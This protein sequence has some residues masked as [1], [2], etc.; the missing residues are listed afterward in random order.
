MTSIRRF[1]VI[2]LLATI[3]LFN[4]IAAIQ[5]YRT[6]MR[7]TGQMLDAQLANVARVISQT[8]H[9]HID[10]MT[11]PAIGDLAVQI[12]SEKQRLLYHTSNTPPEPVSDLTEGFAYSNFAGYHWRIHRFF[13]HDTRQWI[14][15]AERMD[16]RYQVAESIVLKTLFPII[17][18]LPIIGL[19][20]WLIVGSGLRPLRELAHQLGVKKSSDLT[21]LTDDNT[22]IELSQLQASI[23]KLLSRLEHSFNREKR[24][25]GDAAHELRTPLS[26][27]KTQIYNLQKQLPPDDPGIRQVNASIDRMT[28]LIEQM[29]VLYRTTPEQFLACFDEV[30]IHTLAQN[31]IGKLYD[32]IDRKQQTIELQGEHCRLVGDAFALEAML[33]NL[34]DNASKY[35]PEKGRILVSIREEADTIS[36][37]VEDSGPG[38][39][40]ELHER[41]FDRFYRA[42]GDMHAST[43]IGCGLGLS[44]VHHIVDLHQGMITLGPSQFQSGLAVH[45]TLPKQGAGLND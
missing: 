45:I 3:T 14:V 27:L 8:D 16:N 42:N 17:A 33:K 10:S 32:N 11:L 44:I 24:F 22:P 39:D 20:I 2:V 34:I 6:G 37:S 41:V 9:R 5:G 23:N 38:I 31:V 21:P 15:V 25:S 35:T 26:V 13:S 19:L 36:I 29:L 12:F 4:F 43:A 28:H 18:G 7:E 40:S 1:L 30:D